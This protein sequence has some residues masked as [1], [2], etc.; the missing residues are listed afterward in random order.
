MRFHLDGSTRTESD[1]MGKGAT[2]YHCDAE[3]E[4]ASLKPPYPSQVT[5][6]SPSR[7]YRKRIA[8]AGSFNVTSSIA[9]HLSE[10]PKPKQ[11]DWD[12]ATAFRPRKGVY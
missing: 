5:Y 7:E 11:W 9:M 1:G 3:P 8:Q 10:L 12:H 6:P 2:C 4:H